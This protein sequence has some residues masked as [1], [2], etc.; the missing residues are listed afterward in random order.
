MVSA[1]YLAGLVDGEGYIGLARI[2]RRPSPEYCARVAIYNTNRGILDEVQRLWGGTMS[3][4]PERRA[5]WKRSYALIWT[6][7]AASLLLGRIV[8]NLRIKE[9]QAR[10]LLQFHGRLRGLRRARDVSGRLLPLDSGELAF[11]EALYQKIKL[12]NRP[13]CRDA[14]GP[15]AED[16][17]RRPRGEVSVEYLAG[18][19]DG[20]GSIMIQRRPRSRGNRVARYSAR[21][22]IANTNRTVLED[23]RRSYGGLLF[24][25]APRKPGWSRGYQLVWTD[26]MVEAFLSQVIDHLR[27][28]QPQGLTV[29]RF[30]A[31]R[32]T[33]R[34]NRDPAQMSDS[35]DSTAIVER[36]FQRMKEL[37]ARGPPTHP[38]E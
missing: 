12:L 37:N 13:G 21:V 11:R 9:P 16:L 36:L 23:I 33:D 10:L 22:S 31:Q 30:L 32:R 4:I 38:A 24:S 6:N 19:V 3:S 18:F 28:K 14:S 15:H 26:P 27:V 5:A 35:G 8:P 2:P 34:V 1:E 17:P 29:A 7:A 20:E 25:Q